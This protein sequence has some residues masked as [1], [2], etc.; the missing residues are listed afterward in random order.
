MTVGYPDNVRLSRGGQFPLFNGANIAP[1]TVVPFFSGYVGLFPFINST[2]NMGASTDFAQI[3]YTWYQDNTFA[4]VVGFRAANRG[5]NNLAYAQYA[6]LSDW[7]QVFY[8]TKSGNPMTFVEISLYGTQQPSEPR[9]LA[10]QDTGIWEVNTTVAASTT[11]TYPLTKIIPG[12]GTL[13]LFSGAVAWNVNVQYYDYGLNAFQTLYSLDQNAFADA[14]AHIQIPVLDTPM[15]MQF[16]NQDAAAR[17]F[18]AI[19]AV[20]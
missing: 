6:N 14:A 12:V 5:G 13:T 17:P 9:Q 16:H 4:N 8:H 10:S 11:N 20:M 3:T 7:M 18:Q 15:Q 19:L 2:Q 1:A